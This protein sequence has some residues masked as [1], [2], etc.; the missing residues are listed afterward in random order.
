MSDFTGKT[1]AVTYKSILKINGENQE[2]DGVLRSVTDGVGNVSCL[3]LSTGGFHISGDALIDGFTQIAELECSGEA[4]FQSGLNVADHLEA[5]TITSQGKLTVE[6]E[7]SAMNEPAEFSAVNVDDH[8]DADSIETQGDLTVGGVFSV[9]GSCNLSDDLDINDGGSI[10]ID[11]GDLTVGG[12][13]SVG[14]DLNVTGAVEFGDDFEVTGETNLGNTVIVDGALLEVFDGSSA[15]FQVQ[16]GDVTINADMAFTGDLEF[17]GDATFGSNCKLEVEG[18]FTAEAGGDVFIFGSLESEAEIVIGNSNVP[19]AVVLGFDYEASEGGIIALKELVTP[20]T[21][22][23]ETSFLYTKAADGKMYYTTT[24]GSPSEFEIAVIGSSFNPDYTGDSV[25]VGTNA[26]I[27]DDGTLNRAVAIGYEALKAATTA[28]SNVAIGHKS[29][30]GINGSGNVAVG[31]NTLSESTGAPADNTAVGINALKNGDCNRNV[32][33]GYDA[34]FEETVGS[35]QTAV[36]YRALY[37]A[38]WESISDIWRNNTAIGRS[39][40]DAIVEGKQNVCIGAYADASVDDS[41]NEIV[42]GYQT[43]GAGSNTV[44]I[45]NA[46]VTNNYLTGQLS[47]SSYGSGTYTGTD[48][49]WLAVDSSGNIIEEAPPAGGGGLATSGTNYIY[50]E[51][52]GTATDNGTELTDAYTTAS[53]A[54]Y[55]PV[56]SATNRYVIVCPPGQYDLGSG[57]LVLDT[58]FIDI[59]STTGERDVILIT[60]ATDDGGAQSG[61]AIS[62]ETDDC[63]VVGVV[64]LGKRFQ[65]YNGGGA[66][67][68]LINCQGHEKSFGFKSVAAGYHEKCE[69]MSGF[70]FGTVS[71]GDASG[72]FVD[73]RGNGLYNFGGSAGIAS[74]T[75][76]RC[77]CGDDYGFASYWGETA[78]GYFFM[79]ENRDNGGGSFGDFGSGS[80][81]VASGDFWYCKTEKGGSFGAGLNS[82]FS[83][84]A[85]YCT[86]GPYSFGSRFANVTEGGGEFTGAAYYCYA[87]EES[88][89]GNEAAHSS[90]S[91]TAYYCIAGPDSFANDAT[92]NFSGSIKLCLSDDNELNA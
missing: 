39:A 60:T 76:I 9:N 73:C 72:V 56:L 19:Q 2:M 85:W 67:Y 1:P 79:C 77:I 58:D 44:T 41:Y 51:A 24:D 82:E 42:I 14:G 87:E 52:D 36:G 7:L 3:Q 13:A 89:G 8:L 83:G 29:C 11:T 47:L 20:P 49:K 28:G 57:T 69:A 68:R 25:Y 61:A 50:L 55:S 34:L 78:S 33:V 5:S 90:F 48:A 53:G 91:G 80:S 35:G 38:N 32:A 46:S 88:F 15:C 54:V 4:D 84:N 16:S 66:D 27:N 22:E 71:G 31:Y 12:D 92:I 21:P 43:T 75:F 70:A 26:G 86:A 64:A 18:S 45:G 40:G 59:K 23:N 81:S 10:N 30:T 63:V 37:N 65:I 74:G 6:G 62:I 17:D